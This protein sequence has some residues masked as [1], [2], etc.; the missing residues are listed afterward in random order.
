MVPSN[1]RHAVVNNV[2]EKSFERLMI[3]SDVP[4]LKRDHLDQECQTGPQ[5]VEVAAGFHSNQAAAHQTPP[6]SSSES[7]LNLIT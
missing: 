7:S 3:C 5:R 4:I 6:I 2:S 1:R